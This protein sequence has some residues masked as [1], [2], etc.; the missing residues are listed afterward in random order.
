MQLDPQGNHVI[1][2]DGVNNQRLSVFASNGSKS[3]Y[4][5]TLDAE[6]IG[7]LDVAGV[8]SLNINTNSRKNLIVGSTLS[9]FKGNVKVSENNSDS[10]NLGVIN[11]SSNSYAYTRIYLGNDQY[12][13]LLQLFVNS[14]Q[15]TSDGGAGNTTM[16]TSSGKLHLGAGGGRMMTLDNSTQRL[17]VGTESPSYKLH[18][19]GDI[20]ANGGWLRSSG[21]TGWY[22]ETYGGGW[23][24][25]DGTYIRNYGG[26]ELFLDNNITIQPADANTQR[27][28]GFAHS[29][30]ARSIRTGGSWM[31][32]GTDRA[33][34]YDANLRFHSWNGIG[35]TPSISGQPIPQGENAVYINV[36]N[37][38]LT[39]R[40]TI[41]ANRL[42]I[43]VGY[44]L[45]ATV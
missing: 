6:N 44:D 40:G 16:R 19:A 26:K 9:E 25:T 14:S 30:M 41:R 12:P 42:V 35:F 5:T 45:F 29:S 36:R 38:D 22:N 24:M 3:T 18:V 31:S 43:P 20:F 32:S 11:T 33:D 2:Y 10:I 15:K 8:N 27:W 1:I 34:Y 17:G 7:L 4:V 23:H 21:A 39:A 13:D 28:I 37:G